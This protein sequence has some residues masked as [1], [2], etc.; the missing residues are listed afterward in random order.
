MPGV[1]E[2][3]EQEVVCV[4]FAEMLTGV[5]GQVTVRLEGA[6]ELSVTVPA[7]LKVLVRV[8]PTETPTW[9]TLRLAPFAR[10]VKSP[11]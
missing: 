9:P 6:L 8:T 7:K 3:S 11:T 2:E 1:V 10:I 5:E 4:A